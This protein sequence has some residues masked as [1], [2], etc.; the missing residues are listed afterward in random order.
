MARW[1]TLLFVCLF[2]QQADAEWYLGG[3]IGGA[4]PTTITRADVRSATLPSGT[5]F[6]NV[7]LENSVMIGGKA[8]YWFT[9]Q[10]SEWVGLETNFQYANPDIA[11]QSIRTNLPT[12]FV[13]IAPAACVGRTSCAVPWNGAD[14][15]VLTWAPFIIKA[16]YPNGPWQPYAGIG[17]GLFFAK[18]NA[19]GSL[20][21]DNRAWLGYPTRSGVYTRRSIRA[22]RRVGLPTRKPYFFVR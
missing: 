6:S 13:F 5:T 7:E 21:V 14:L 22:V 15:R 18:T 1:L 4:F 11:A 10:G 9:K 16:R 17:L 19:L 12:G 8:G 2:A 3:Q 20:H